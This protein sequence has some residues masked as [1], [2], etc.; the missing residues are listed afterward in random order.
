M[1]HMSLG[2]SCEY[3]EDEND[4][5]VETENQLTQVYMETGC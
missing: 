4:W 5:R 3:A 2:L 1:Y